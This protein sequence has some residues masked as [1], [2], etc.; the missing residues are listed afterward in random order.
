M[1]PVRWG[2]AG[3]FLCPVDLIP[4]QPEFLSGLK[5]A[6]AGEALSDAATQTLGAGHGSLAGGDAWEDEVFFY[7]A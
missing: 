7:H 3:F 1:L 2:A 4:G 5:P 6:H